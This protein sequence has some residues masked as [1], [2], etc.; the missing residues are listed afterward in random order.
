MKTPIHFTLYS[1]LAATFVAFCQAA[2][3][4][5]G[6][7][8]IFDGKDLTG[9]D[10]N[11][12]LWSVKDGAITGA[13][14]AEAPIKVN[15]FLIWTNGSP[16]DFELRLKYRI[17]GN[18]PGNQANSGIQYRSKVIDQSQWI[19]GG[20]QAD[21]EAGNN[22]TGI[23]YEER[24]SRGIMALRGEKVLWTADGKKQVTGKL[25]TAEEVQAV[26]K[27]G[28]WND[29]RIVAKGNVLQHFINGKQS[30]EVVDE[31]K[32]KA[33]TSGIIG[34]QLH[35]GPPMT[36]QFKDIQLRELK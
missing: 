28:D 20:Y 25:G 34:L 1:L 35:V 19:A 29:Y 2:E 10:G 11:P 7:K 32:D 13:T 27:S 21:I 23:L 17:V 22:Y 36:V 3:P 15:T 26:I 16:G 33:A 4:Q 5:A 31:T 30:L 14:T 9:W 8:S 6:F 12:A 18:N 24:M